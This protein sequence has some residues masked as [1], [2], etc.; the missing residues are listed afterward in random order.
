MNIYNK[1]PLIMRGFLNI[2]RV[3]TFSMSLIMQ[4]LQANF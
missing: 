3:Y 4:K 2:L 1:K